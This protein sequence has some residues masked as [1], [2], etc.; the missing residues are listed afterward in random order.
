M[1][2]EIP[3]DESFSPMASD[4][5]MFRFLRRIEARRLIW[6]ETPARA[7]AI[8]SRIADLPV[9]NSHKSPKGQRSLKQINASLGLSR[10]EVLQKAKAN[11]MRL[12]GREVI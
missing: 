5:A 3:V 11:T 10:A 1:I 6:D 2:G 12:L 4:P 7:D 9:V 8:V